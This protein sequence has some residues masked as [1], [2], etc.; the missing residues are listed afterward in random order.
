MRYAT[1]WFRVSR[2]YIYYTHLIWYHTEYYIILYIYIYK[3]ALYIQARDTRL[4]VATR[5]TRLSRSHLPTFTNVV[6]DRFLI[7]HSI[8]T[9]VSP[10]HRDCAKPVGKYVERVT[11][12]FLPTLPKEAEPSALTTATSCL[13]LD[14]R[15]VFPSTFRESFAR[16]RPLPPPP[17]FRLGF[18]SSTRQE[19]MRPT[20]RNIVTYVAS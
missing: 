14:L 2:T 9:D 8:S 6:F 4:V 5:L 1:R 19:N 13:D 12:F 11:R 20:Y 15:S 3:I 16:V 18:P 7:G 10:S 17:P